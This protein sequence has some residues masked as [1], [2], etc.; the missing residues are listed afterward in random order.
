[1]SGSSSTAKHGRVIQAPLDH[2]HGCD[3]GHAPWLLSGQG[4]AL[5]TAPQGDKALLISQFDLPVQNA[6]SH[7]AVLKNG[8]LKF[9]PTSSSRRE[10]IPK[11][12]LNGPIAIE[13]IEEAFDKV[14]HRPTVGSPRRFNGDQTRFP[15]PHLP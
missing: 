6:H 12:Q 8:Y 3:R 2:V 9:G 10:P 14:Q 15:H 1:L 13:E 11:F 4:H 7:A 5:L